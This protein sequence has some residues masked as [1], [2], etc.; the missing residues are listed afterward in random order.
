MISLNM[1]LTILSNFDLNND[2]DYPDLFSHLSSTGFY[3]AD[4]LSENL[5]KIYPDIIYSSPF[6]SALQ[7]I[8][9]TCKKY[10]KYINI[11]NS[12]CPPAKN[13]DYGLKLGEHLDITT[14]YNYLTDVINTNYKSSLLINNIPYSET[15]VDITNRIYPFLFKIYNTYH[16]TNYNVCL[17]THSSITKIIVDYFKEYKPH[18]REIEYLIIN[19]KHYPDELYNINPLHTE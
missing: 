7:T 13:I 16:L 4:G 3:K 17:V 14:H 18:E 12:L 8:Y 10:N 1:K 6:L 19:D 9:P 15:P 2:L 11:D 5:K